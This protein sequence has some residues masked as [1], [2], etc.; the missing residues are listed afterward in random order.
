MMFAPA[1][2]GPAGNPYA[3]IQVPRLPVPPP[4]TNL[5]S[6]TPPALAQREP[7]VRGQR[8]DGPA[9]ATPAAAPAPAAIL[10][11]TP[12]SLPPPAALGLAA[13]AEMD[14]TA[15]RQRLRE[16]GVVSFKVR[17]ARGGWHFVCEVPTAR[18]GVF[19]HIES[20]PAATEA[21]A[22]TLALAE[23]SRWRGR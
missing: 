2:Q 9:P 13:P 8:E 7:I 3:N 4:E 15:T 23:A 18:V 6:S 16:L 5:A 11:L 22:V 1:G 14:W 10:D 17:E 21:E 20:G 19:H 12:P